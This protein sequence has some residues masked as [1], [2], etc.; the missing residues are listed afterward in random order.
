MGAGDLSFVLNDSILTLQSSN[1]LLIRSIILQG[2][3]LNPLSITFSH[4]QL[5]IMFV[6][7]HV[8]KTHSSLENAFEGQENDPQWLL[9]G[10]DFGPL[11]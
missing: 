6:D 2:M 11:P 8:C 10:G 3:P 1:G 7:L 9:S 4:V 5:S